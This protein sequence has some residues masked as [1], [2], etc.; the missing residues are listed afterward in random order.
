MS[1]QNTD[2]FTNQVEQGINDLALP[3]SDAASLMINQMTTEDVIDELAARLGVDADIIG[4]NLAAMPSIRTAGVITDTSVSHITREAALAIDPSA[5]D[6]VKE[7]DPNNVGDWRTA[8]PE[9]NENFTQSLD[10]D[11]PNPLADLSDD[12]I[13]QMDFSQVAAPADYPN[14]VDEDD[15]SAAWHARYADNYPSELLATSG[16]TEQALEAAQKFA[17][18][19][20]KEDIIIHKDGATNTVAQEMLYIFAQWLQSG[21]NVTLVQVLAEQKAALN[22]SD[23]V[24]ANL[25]KMLEHYE[26]TEIR[27][28][29]AAE[30]WKNSTDFFNEVIVGQPEADLPAPLLDRIQAFVHRVMGYDG[31]LSPMLA[32]L[33]LDQP[34]A[35]QAVNDTQKMFMMI[36]RLERAASVAD[37]IR[38][39]A[40]KYQALNR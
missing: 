1:E 19:E 17:D 28:A 24:I 29:L 13:A 14:N 37:S 36:K 8:S 2:S 18:R 23:T 12:E 34:E 10:A 15:S 16:N 40:A 39:D 33:L 32:E 5:M 35:A 27:D 7:S 38:E 30:L 21:D 26:Q 25:E 9:Q 3:E 22:H 4:R 6:A 31:D 20:T 11:Q